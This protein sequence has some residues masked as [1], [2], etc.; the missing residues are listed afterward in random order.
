[1]RYYRV[2]KAGIRLTAEQFLRLQT[3]YLLEPEVVRRWMALCDIADDEGIW[4]SLSGGWRDGDY[5][6]NEFFRRYTYSG[7]TRPIG[8]AGK[9]AKFYIGDNTHAMGWYTLNAGKIPCATP[10]N[11]WH[12][13]GRPGSDQEFVKPRAIDGYGNIRWAADNAHRVGLR[14]SD[15]AQELHHLEPIE[16]STSRSKYD[17]VLHKLTVFDLPGDDEM[18]EAF[19]MHVKGDEAIFRVTHGGAVAR[20]VR[21]HQYGPGAKITAKPIPVEPFGTQVELVVLELIEIHGDGPWTDP[22]YNGVVQR[23]HFAP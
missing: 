7:P 4:L 12:T 20:W 11:G 9:T 17:P 18:G 15:I 21:H 23:K 6:A 14:A 16:S 3:V 2:G 19:Y 10:W 8:A 22:N 1:M 13:F 5:A